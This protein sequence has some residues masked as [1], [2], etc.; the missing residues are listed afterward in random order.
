MM[1]MYQNVQL[2]IKND[3]PPHIDPWHNDIRP[4]CTQQNVHV[5]AT[6]PVFP[7]QPP[8]VIVVAVVLLL[9]LCA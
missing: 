2:L 7:L 5:L 6:V 3:E 1:M 8:V 4:T 9:V